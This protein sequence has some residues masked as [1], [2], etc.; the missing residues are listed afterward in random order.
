MD[1]RPVYQAEAGRGRPG[2]TYTGQTMELLTLLM[3]LSETDSMD[4][5]VVVQ[6]LLYSES[7][8]TPATKLGQRYPPTIARIIVGNCWPMRVQTSRR[9]NRQKP[10]EPSVP[11]YL[12]FAL[13]VQSSYCWRKS[14]F[15]YN[16]GAGAN[17]IKDIDFYSLK[18][19]NGHASV[20]PVFLRRT[21][22][23]F[24]SF[25]LFSSLCS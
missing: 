2:V 7:A 12:L 11:W 25:F 6:R 23:S 22:T 17:Q 19:A 14:G 15:Y 3:M 21:A 24:F 8:V 1:R 10:T 20:S 13:M 9:I 4:G 5:F 18:V 16:L